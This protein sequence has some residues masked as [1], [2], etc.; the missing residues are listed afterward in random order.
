MNEPLL[1]FWAFTV[2]DTFERGLDLRKTNHEAIEL[3]DHQLDRYSFGEQKTLYS[4]VCRAPGGARGFMHKAQ[5]LFSRFHGPIF[6]YHRE[7]PMYG[8]PASASGGGGGGGGGAG[9][10]IFINYPLHVL[11]DTLNI[12]ISDEN[13]SRIVAAMGTPPSPMRRIR[14]FHDEDSDLQR[15]IRAS[16]EE[17]AREL[18]KQQ[19]PEQ[20]QDWSSVLKVAEPA[21]NGF[22]QCTVC[23]ENK[24]TICIVECGHQ[25]LCD[26]CVPK[27]M[28]HRCVICK[29][30]F[31]RIVRPIWPLTKEKEV[32]LCSSEPVRKRQRRCK[33]QCT[34]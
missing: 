17:H 29:A 10:N 34:K 22:A 20:A 32:E 16:E 25:A 24:A 4:T 6:V 9:E 33:T 23:F 21:I 14:L 1:V 28:Q 15:A 27:L 12:R 3:D 19:P 31:K 2:R 5:Q 7:I 26:E 8:P 13:K 30:D 18:Q 11:L